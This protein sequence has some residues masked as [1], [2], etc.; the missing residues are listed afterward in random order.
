MSY[1]N[2]ILKENEELI[3]LI[4]QHPM[5]FFKPGLFALFLI[6]LPFFLMFLLFK[7][8][9]FG[10][11]LFII[12]LFIGTIALIRLIVVWHYNV[13]LI[14]DRRVILFKQH[15]LFD[16]HVSEIEYEKIQPILT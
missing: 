4:H 16:R 1:F 5:V 8:E 14:T 2:K 13:F 7:W 9:I 12:L 10:L 3:R 6:V 15:G 11:I